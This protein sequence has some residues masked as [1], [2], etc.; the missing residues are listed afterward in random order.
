MMTELP[1][2]RCHKVVRAAKIRTVSGLDEIE[3][4]TR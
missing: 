1:R 3:P 2:Y 4:G